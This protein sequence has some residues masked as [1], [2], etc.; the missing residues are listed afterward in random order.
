MYEPALSKAWRGELR[1]SAGKFKAYKWGGFTGRS[2]AGSAPRLIRRFRGAAAAW[3]FS[4]I[5]SASP[6]PNWRLIH[7]TVGHCTAS[8]TGTRRA[9]T[10]AQSSPPISAA[11]CAADSR[12]TPSSMRGQRNLP[13]ASWRTGRCRPR[14]SA[15]RFYQ[16]VIFSGTDVR[17]NQ[18]LT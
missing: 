14:R 16:R 12:I 7:F 1:I 11:N 4:S 17:G 9:R 15:G 8:G 2:E 10:R 13:P 6:E 3:A 18:P 5:A